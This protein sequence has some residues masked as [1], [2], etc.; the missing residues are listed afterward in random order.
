MRAKTL[1][2]R[3]STTPINLYLATIPIDKKG[4]YEWKFDTRSRYVVTLSSL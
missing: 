3:P 1:H 4:R 2:R